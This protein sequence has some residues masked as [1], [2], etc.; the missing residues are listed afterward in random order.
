MEQYHLPNPLFK[1]VSQHGLIYR[2]GSSFPTTEDHHKPDK[3]LEGMLERTCERWLD[4]HNGWR[5]SVLPPREAEVSVLRGHEMG[6][7]H[8][9]LRP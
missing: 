3:R 7:P 9:P 2:R 1:E 4:G 5:V 6:V 8:A